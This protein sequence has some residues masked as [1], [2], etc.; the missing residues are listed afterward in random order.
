MKEKDKSSTPVSELGKIQLTERYY[1]LFE[2]EQSGKTPL[3]HEDA[4]LLNLQKQQVLSSLK[5]FAEGVHFNLVYFPLRHLGFKAVTASISDIYAMNATPSFISVNIAVSNKFYVEHLDEFFEGMRLACEK[6]DIELAKFDITTSLT[7]LIISIETIGEAH[8]AITYR[9]GAKPTD[10][11]CIT[12][13]FGAAYMGLQVLERERRIFV[14]T[15]GA[16]PIL[17]NYK[18]IIE[19]QLKPE[20]RKE[21]IG[22]LHKSSLQPSS[23]TAVNEGLAYG[24]LSLCKASGT[25]CKIFAEKIPIDS[26]TASAANEMN[27]EPLTCALNGGE[28]YELLFTIALSDFDKISSHPEIKVIGHM[29][30]DPKEKVLIFESGSTVPLKA[31]GWME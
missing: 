1:S 8:G 4:A 13:N 16:Q 12:G 22:L 15:G 19:R 27:L 29:V 17:E 24:I 5:L 20:A 2:K 3:L 26:E 31:Q 10:L 25:G 23:M 6:Y 14:S 18:Y 21:I 9:K 7:G 11:I 30:T 28:D